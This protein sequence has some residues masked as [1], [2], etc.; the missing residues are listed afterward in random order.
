V[1][2]VAQGVSAECAYFR[3]SANLLKCAA[4][5]AET[6]KADNPYAA[7]S[8]DLELDGPGAQRFVKVDCA[9]EY[10]L[11]GS[12]VRCDTDQSMERSSV[13][14]AEKPAET[15]LRG[16]TLCKDVCPARLP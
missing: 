11:M 5:D 7:R 3:T 12:D 4:A 8:D 6:V 13:I 1:C 15:C 10:S 9:C 16:R 14:G 2:S